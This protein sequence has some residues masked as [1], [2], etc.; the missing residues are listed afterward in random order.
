MRSNTGRFDIVAT[1]PAIS[2]Y[3]TMPIDAD[4]PPTHASAHAE[5][6]AGLGVRDEVADVDEPAEGREDAEED[7]EDPLHFTTLIRWPLRTRR[8]CPRS[9]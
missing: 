3:T 9:S 8:G 5:A 4:A 7:L 6:R 2:A 1:R